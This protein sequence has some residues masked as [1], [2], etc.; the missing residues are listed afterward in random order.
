MAEYSVL[1]A[2]G[3]SNLF[4]ERF[5]GRRWRAQGDWVVGSRLAADLLGSSFSARAWDNRAA[6]RA[7]DNH[8]S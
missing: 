5:S 3:D 1:R 4:I 7:P 2:V 6:S 8:F